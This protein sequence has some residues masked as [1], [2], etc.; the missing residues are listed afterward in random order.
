MRKS[1]AHIITILSLL[2]L[3]SSVFAQTPLNVEAPSDLDGDG[4]SDEDEIAA[5]TDPSVPDVETLP[6][7]PEIAPA[8]IFAVGEP[9]DIVIEVEPQE[10]P[11]PVVDSGEPEPE[12]IAEEAPEF[13]DFTAE[14]PTATDMLLTGDDGVTAEEGEPLIEQI[15]GKDDSQAIEEEETL[16]SQMT[17]QEETTADPTLNIRDAL[18][19]EPPEVEA[20]TQEQA[21]QEVPTAGG[22]GRPRLIDLPAPIKFE[23]PARFNSIT[24]R[25]EIFVDVEKADPEQSARVSLDNIPAEGVD[26]ATF[27]LLSPLSQCADSPGRIAHDGKCVFY[28]PVDRDGDGIPE[29]VITTDDSDVSQFDADITIS[30]DKVVAAS[31]TIPEGVE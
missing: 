9:V 4:I 31:F 28:G 15:A 11:E 13:I 17:M 24:R 1:I 2:I 10:L 29:R 30:G 8:P 27:R 21:N 12:L 5:G 7:A 23:A 26:A 22:L 20:V 19:P 3:T 14:A 6:V 25:T 18:S 16:T